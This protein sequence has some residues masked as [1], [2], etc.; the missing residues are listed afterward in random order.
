MPSGLSDD[1][2]S[3]TFIHNGKSNFIV[4]AGDDDLHDI[5]ALINVIGPYSGKKAIPSATKVIT[6]AAD[7]DWTIKRNH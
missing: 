6:I 2:A 4:S 5:A 1:R 3:Y 7:G